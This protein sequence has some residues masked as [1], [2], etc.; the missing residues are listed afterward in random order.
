MRH[1]RQYDF[2]GHPR[3]WSRSG[4]D[5]GPL[6]GLFFFS[7]FSS[8]SLPS[9]HNRPVSFSGQMLWESTKPGFSLLSKLTT[10]VMVNM[11]W[12]IFPKVQ[13]LGQTSA[14]KYYYFWRYPSMKWRVPGQEVDQRKLGERLWK[15]T[16][17]HMDCT[18]RMPWIVLDGRIR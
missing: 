13:S 16:V 1:S 18:G 4:D 5:L 15:K 9:F 11:P 12:H 8:Y 6:S 17:G 10:L 2:Q 7:Y 14:G 3:S